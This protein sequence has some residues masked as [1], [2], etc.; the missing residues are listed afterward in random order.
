MSQTGVIREDRATEILREIN[1]IDC[2]IDELNRCARDLRAERNKR[3]EEYRALIVTDL[4]ANGQSAIAP[5][6]AG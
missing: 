6:T 1:R 5:G 4:G 2:R 3:W